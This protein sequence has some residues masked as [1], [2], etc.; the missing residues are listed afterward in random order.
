MLVFNFFYQT[1]PILV[2]YSFKQYF[3][4]IIFCAIVS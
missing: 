3:E 4:D 1:C 2:M